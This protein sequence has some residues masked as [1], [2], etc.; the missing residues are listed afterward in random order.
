MKKSDL[1]KK[2]EIKKREHSAIIGGFVTSMDSDTNRTGGYDVM[3]STNKDGE[4]VGIDI[5][6]TFPGDKDKPVLTTAP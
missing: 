1:F 4:Y 6:S 3:E 5:V 2:F